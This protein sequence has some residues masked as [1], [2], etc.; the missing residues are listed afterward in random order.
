MNESDSTAGP[1]ISAGTLIEALY[2]I[3]WTA[4]KEGNLD[5]ISPCFYSFTGLQPGASL[6]WTWTTVL[7]PDDVPL[8]LDRWKHSLQTGQ[9]YQTEYRIRQAANGQYV[10]HL[11]RANPVRDKAGNITRWVGTSVDIHQQKL[12]EEGLQTK[13]GIEEKIGERTRDL[14]FKNVELAKANE[15]MESVVHIAG[16]DLRS[17][18]NNLKALLNIYTHTTTEE[19]KEQIIRYMQE[20]VHRLDKTVAGLLRFLEVHNPNESLVQ[21]LS[22]AEAFDVVMADYREEAE[23]QNACICASFHEQPHIRFNETFL[24][25]ILRNLVSNALKYR[26]SKRRLQLQ[27]STCRDGEFVCLIVKD[28]GIGMDATQVRDKLFKPFSRL[29]GQADGKGIGLH[30]VKN[31]V[32]KNGGFIRVQTRLDAG[33]TFLV[34]LKEYA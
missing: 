17:P 16:H 2:Q 9:P 19:E 28:N 11:V 5:Y 15:V 7:H 20:S 23:K 34:N 6:G 8:S 13:E 27:I 30:L 25:S 12:R 26:S 14:L 21:T 33:T 1:G 4:D 32:E 3:I 18:I 22:F 31:M 10:W 29:S 24:L